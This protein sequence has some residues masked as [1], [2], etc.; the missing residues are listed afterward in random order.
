M[1]NPIQNLAPRAALAAMLLLASTA[2]LPA[3]TNDEARLTLGMAAGYIGSHVLWTVPN[4]PILSSFDPP[5]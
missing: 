3:Q 2:K 1:I 4:Q 5:S